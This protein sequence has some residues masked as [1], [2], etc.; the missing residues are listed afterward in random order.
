M[1][2]LNPD[3]ETP[4]ADPGQAE[5]WT[6]IV[7]T[8][9]ERIGG[10]GPEPHRAWEDFERWVDFKGDLTDVEVILAFFDHLA[11]GFEDF[12]EGWDNDLYLFDL[13][14]GQLVVCPFDG[15]AVEEMESDWNNDNYAWSWEHVT[16]E[17]GQ[18]D[19]E[20]VEDFEDLWRANEAYT[21]SWSDVASVT[22]MFDEGAQPVEDF[23]NDWTAADTI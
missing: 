3:F 5:H 17:A 6:L 8:A 18:F 13:P 4:G 1:A 10:F 21:W 23:E 7:H 11:E 12:N 20:T 9:A 14:T 16:A 2:I 19:N 15:G 22:A